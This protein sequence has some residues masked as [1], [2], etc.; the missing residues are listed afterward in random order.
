MVRIN[1]KVRIT[2]WLLLLLVPAV[3][4]M[5][6]DRLQAADVGAGRDIST[7]G[8]GETINGLGFFAGNFV[9]VD[10]TVEGTTFA[11][12]Q[13]VRI[14][15]IIN[16]DLFAAAQ[17]ITINGQVNGNIYTAG[18]NVVIGTRTDGDVFAAG[19]TM[20]VSQEAV[21]GRDLMAAAQT[22]TMDGTVQRHFNGGGSDVV[23][24]GSIGQN[25][26][27]EAEHLRILPGAAI[28]GDLTY[29]SEQEAEIAI[30][31]NIL[32]RRDW[33]PMDKKT[34]MPPKNT[35]ARTAGSILL[36]IVGALLVWFLLKVWRSDFWNVL[37]DPLEDQPLKVIGMGILVFLLTPLL[38]ILLMITV[39]GIPLGI[40]LGILYG[41]MIY[42][43]KI[44]V[45]VFMGSWMTKRFGWQERHMG[46]WPVLLSLT[47][48]VLLGK[49]PFAGML[50][51]L[52]IL[53]AGLGALIMSRQKV[54]ARIE[55]P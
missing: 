35:A 30:G 53:L 55:E 40:L 15:G 2:A 50:L 34:Y 44:I 19:Q 22:V 25:A 21:I 14:N 37:A 16:G 51:K 29:R 31:S 39:I 27:V 7:L 47:I 42:L 8:K 54:P 17:T 20:K 28:K 43:S 18:Q 3:L 33:Q 32:G 6:S 41:V 11:S 9:Q 5:L 12:G 52:V 24:G 13:E 45:A 38:I 49:V 1:K 46:I 48:L 26:D 4:L 36:N 23:I 10:G